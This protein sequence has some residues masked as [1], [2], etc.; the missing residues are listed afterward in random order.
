LEVAADPAESAKAVGLRY[1][2]D[3]LHGIHR[4]E[5]GKNFRYLAPNG[6]PVAEEDLRRIRSLAIPPAWTDVWI[7]PLP[8]GHLQATGHDIKGRKQ[9]RYHPR[10]R[11]VRDESKYSR[12]VEFGK[13][14]PR[15]RE[16][17]QRDMEL[18]GLPK[19]KVL[20]TVV[21]LLEV[22]LIRVGNEEYARVHSALRVSGQVRQTTRADGR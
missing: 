18:P 21:R 3:R 11:E 8:N 20:A 7:C 22:S 10:W 15:I 4:A 5:A 13:V 1:V 2:T 6:K 17:V 16:Q 14:L 9:Y 19:R 12:M